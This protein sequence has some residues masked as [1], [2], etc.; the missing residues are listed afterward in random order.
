MIAQRLAFCAV[1]TQTRGRFAALQRWHRATKVALAYGAGSLS[2]HCGRH[3]YFAMPPAPT[4]PN[5]LPAVKKSASG[6][7]PSH[8]GQ[9]NTSLWFS[10]RVRVHA[11]RQGCRKVGKPWRRHS[12]SQPH[13][14]HG[15]HAAMP[16]APSAVN[17]AGVILIEI[18]ANERHPILFAPSCVAFQAAAFTDGPPD[19]S[20]R[21]GSCRSPGS[22]RDRPCRAC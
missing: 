13:A 1:W 15:L 10:M 16:T 14:L 21:P 22:P 6:V 7:A 5:M 18:R 8:I 2:C 19:A 12:V 9:G 4:T 3:D 17:E 11:C 20:S